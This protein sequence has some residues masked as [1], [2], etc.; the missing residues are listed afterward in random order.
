MADNKD[1]FNEGQDEW[2]EDDLMQ[3]LQ[4]PEELDTAFAADAAEGLGSFTSSDQLQ[5]Y[6]VQLNQNLHQ[7]LQTRKQHKE[8]RKIKNLP[9]PVL[10]LIVILALCMIG[11]AII[12][13]YLSSR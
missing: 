6:V 1:I 11:Y 3:F 7:Q 8:K 9:G 10:A 5:Q 13:L 4:Q 2:T 12:R